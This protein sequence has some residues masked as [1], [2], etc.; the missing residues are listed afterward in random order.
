MLTKVSKQASDG[1]IILEVK[2]VQFSF[3]DVVAG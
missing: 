1:V 2:N 3:L